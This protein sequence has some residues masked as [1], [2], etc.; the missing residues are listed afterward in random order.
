MEGRF[1]KRVRLLAIVSLSVL[2][3]LAF[4]QVAFAGEWAPGLNDHNGAA[5]HARSECVYNGH[6]DNDVEDDFI[7]EQTPAKGRV[8]S[9]GQLIAARIP[10][11]SPEPGVQ[12]FACNPIRSQQAP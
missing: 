7:W 9:G 11:I 10:D 12:G 6:D 3:L 8:Q 4:A 1:L 5:S 2:L